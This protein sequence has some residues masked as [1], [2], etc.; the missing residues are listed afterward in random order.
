MR[1]R[2][3]FVVNLS[4]LPPSASLNFLEWSPKSVP[5]SWFFKG[6]EPRLKTAALRLRIDN[7]MRCDRGK[8]T[9]DA[10][11]PSSSVPCAQNKP[12]SGRAPI[13]L[14]VR[15]T[16]TSG[17]SGG[18]GGGWRLALSLNQSVVRSSS[19]PASTRIIEC[20]R[21]APRDQFVRFFGQLS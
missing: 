14:E 19:R 11:D 10:D 2:A 6:E 18:T 1:A 7:I 15:I 17:W 16:L 3:P 4:C 12:Q 5:S 13:Q 20:S 21:C 8:T 9:T